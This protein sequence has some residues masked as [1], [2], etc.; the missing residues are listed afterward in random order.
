MPIK[1]DPLFNIIVCISAKS[2]FTSPIEKVLS[3]LSNVPLISYP[4][5]DNGF[6]FFIG[7]PS[8]AIS[9]YYKIDIIGLGSPLT[10]PSIEANVIDAPSGI[11][12]SQFFGIEGNI[13][14]EDIN[15][16]YV[17]ILNVAGNAYYNSNYEHI[18]IGAAKK[19]GTTAQRPTNVDVGFDYFDATLGKPI[20]WNG[21]VWVDATGT[22]V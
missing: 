12:W 19:Q 16:T 1:A 8:D 11:D 14:I 10:K 22:P 20:Y 7:K 17:P 18:I 2:T 21:T 13:M 9:F 3:E 4:N 6:C 15:N 5:R